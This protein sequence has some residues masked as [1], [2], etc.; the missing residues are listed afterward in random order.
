MAQEVFSFLKR[1]MR[2][3]N[4]CGA[5]NLDMNKAYDRVDWA[6]LKALLLK[7]GFNSHWCN[8]I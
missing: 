2:G 5:L 1:K 8:L 7:F 4:Y 6:F 3:K